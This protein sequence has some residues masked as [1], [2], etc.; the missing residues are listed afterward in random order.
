M[1]RSFTYA[2]VETAAV[3]RDY[4]EE[5]MADLFENPMGLMGF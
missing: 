4:K 5:K 1:S 2:A 3:Q